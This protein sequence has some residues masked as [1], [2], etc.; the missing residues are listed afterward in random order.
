MMRIFTAVILLIL[1]AGCRKDKY[2]ND[3]LQGTWVEKTNRQDT[4]LVYREN[5]RFIMFDKSLSY[6]S[7]P[8]PPLP[9]TNKF[10]YRLLSET[11]IGI[12][13]YDDT[14]ADPFRESDF[15]WITKGKEFFIQAI[16]IR[17][18][19]SSTLA[20]ITYVKIN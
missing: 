6:L 8:G 2:A 16:A 1:I 12:K 10:Q 14:S 5:G 17:L 3:L 4:L 15:R 7:S 18:Y 11:K 9:G 19:M 13:F 20:T